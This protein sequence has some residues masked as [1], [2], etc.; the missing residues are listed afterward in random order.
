LRGEPWLLRQRRDPFSCPKYGRAP[1]ARTRQSGTECRALEA[2]LCAVHAGALYLQLV[3]N[4]EMN[5]I[6]RWPWIYY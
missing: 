4:F 1:L 6:V 2:A 5:T 3:C